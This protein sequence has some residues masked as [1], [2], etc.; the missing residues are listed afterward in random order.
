MIY[1]AIDIETTGLYPGTHQ[2]L[3][4]G[5]IIEDMVTPIENLP[6]FHKYVLSKSY[7]CQPTAIIMNIE[8]M[9]KIN[10]YDWMLPEDDPQQPFPFVREDLL[11]GTFLKWL[12]SY[13]IIENEESPNAFNIGGKN[14]IGFDLPFIRKLPYGTKIRTKHRS[15]DPAILYFDPT[16][17]A[18]LPDLQTCLDRAGIE[19]IVTHT[20]IEDSID[21]IKLV[22]KFYGIPF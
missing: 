16:R 14:V 18:D 7:N 1:T 13:G 12:K 2:I 6:T 5:A 9:K 10:Q 20:A 15:V 17:D 21:V 11:V 22:R 19:K 8:I 4:F 3:E